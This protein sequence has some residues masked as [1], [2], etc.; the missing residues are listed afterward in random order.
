[1]YEATYFCLVNK[2]QNLIIC[3][4]GHV[5]DTTVQVSWAKRCEPR[6]TKI[7]FISMIWTTIESQGTRLSRTYFNVA[8]AM[9]VH[10]LWAGLFKSGKHLNSYVPHCIVINLLF[11]AMFG[12][13]TETI[14][15][16]IS[17][18]LSKH[19]KSGTHSTQCCI[20]GVQIWHWRWHL[21]WYKIKCRMSL[22]MWHGKCQLFKVMLRGW[23]WIGLVVIFKLW[24]HDLIVNI[25][26]LLLLFQMCDILGTRIEDLF[27]WVVAHQQ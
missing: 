10:K 11:K 15:K 7:L 14:K 17:G 24:I 20:F 19:Q 6:G 22:Q 21:F 26:T 13:W 9:L 12:P 2:L 25:F 8:I 5:R 23:K 3:D 1:M 27:E 18:A 4:F 16:Y